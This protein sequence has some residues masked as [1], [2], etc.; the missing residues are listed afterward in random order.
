[1]YYQIMLANHNGFKKVEPAD[2]VQI[3]NKAGSVI[4]TCNVVTAATVFLQLNGEIV[5]KDPELESLIFD[6]AEVTRISLGPTTKI[7]PRATFN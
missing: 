7:V 5:I 4:A 2:P 6:I 3:C 1:M